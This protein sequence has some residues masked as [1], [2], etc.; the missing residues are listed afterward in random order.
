MKSNLAKDEFN[1][2]ISFC[3][4]GR[5]HEGL[6]VAKKIRLNQLTQKNRSIVNK[7]ITRFSATAPTAQN[8]K[9]PIKNI[10]S[11]Y[12]E[13]WHQVL[14][15]SKNQTRL[16]KKLLQKII[17][18]LKQ[19]RQVNLKTSSKEIIINRLKKEIESMGYFCITGT[20]S[21]LQELEI[22]KTQKKAIYSVALPETTEKVTTFLMSE[23]LTKGWV[24][25]ATIGLHYPG[26][27]AKREGLYCNT[28]AYNLKSE[29]FR[30]SYLGHEAQHYSDYKK[31][32]RLG[33]IDLEYRAKLAEFTL[34]KKTSKKMFQVFSSRADYN[35]KSPH[36]F[37]YHCVLRDLAQT[38]KGHGDFKLLAK[39]PSSLKV[40]EIKAAALALMKQH[41]AALRSKGSKKVVSCIS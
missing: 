8:Y 16:E 34:S 13:Y 3:L 7:F 32:P 2:L 23:F 39:K 10:I 33:Q 37:S 9:D 35:K 1:S 30:V 26:G 6:V 41:T 22:W 29:K 18:W 15:N 12:E 14:L 20:V 21:P 4:Q 28:H 31:F 24:A 25:Y 19:F 40:S 17:A 38:M 5:C 27:W 36:A 11:I